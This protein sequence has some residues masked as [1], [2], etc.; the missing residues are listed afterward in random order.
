MRCLKCKKE[1]SDNLLRCNFCNTKVKTV[2]PICGTVNVITSEFCEGCGLQL[3]KYCPECKSVNLPNV[4]QCRK[5]GAK[6]EKDDAIVTISDLND[7]NKPE[8]AP[9]KENLPLSKP[10]NNVAQDDNEPLVLDKADEFDFA[11]EQENSPAETANTEQT[12]DTPEKIDEDELD[13]SEFADSEFENPSIEFEE[14]EN[15]EPSEQVIPEEKTDTPPKKAEEISQEIEQFREELEDDFSGVSNDQSNIKICDQMKCKKLI[16]NAIRNPDK[17]IIGMSAPEGSGKSTVLKYLFGDLMNENHAWLWGECSANSQISPFGIFQEMILTFFNMPNF[18]NMSQDFLKQAKTMLSQTLPNFSQTEIFNLF[19]FLYPTL[20]ANFEDILVN[21]DTTFELLE[22]LI[23]EISKKANLIIVIDDFDMIDGA[24]YEFLSYFVDKGYLGNS[25]KLLITYKD[26]RITQGYFY[27]ENI[28]QNQYEDI[29]LS[30][31]TK[32]DAFNFIKMFF[33][34]TNPLP[35]NIFGQIFEYSQGNSAYIEQILI[36]FNEYKILTTKDGVTKYRKTSIEQKLPSNIYEIL[37]LRLRYLQKKQPSAFKML[38]TAAIMGNKFNIRLLEIIMKMKPQEFQNVTQL[39]CSS[40]YIAQFN[41]NI[42]EFKNTILWKF[43]YE[44]AKQNKD[45]VVLNEKIFDIINSFTL[46]SNALKALIA[47]SLNQ[48]LLALNIWT[49]NVKLCSY[50]GDEH[51]WALSQ[52]QCLK[53]AQETEPEN[54]LVIINNIQERLGKLLYT[55]KP[56]EAIVY[57]SNAISNALKINNQPKIIELAGYLSKSCSLTGNYVGVIEA[58]DTILKIVEP[59]GNKLE[60]ALIKYKKLKAIFSIGNSEEIYNLASN[61]I[62]P[63]VEQALSGVIPN[64]D[65][66]MDVIYETWLECN[67]TVAMAL[68]SQ[69]NKKAFDVLSVI[70]EIVLKNNVENKN[71]L[72]RLKLAKALAFSIQGDIKK[73]DDLLVEF[74]QETSKEIV[75][76]DIISMWNF[77]N[78]LNKLFKHEWQNIK[79]D[80][81]SVVTFANNYNDVL[82]KN[83]LKVFLGKILQEEGNLSKALDI[84][85]EQVTIFAKEKIAIGAMLCWYYIAKITLVTEGTDKALDISQK[86]L[87]VAKNPKISNYYFMVLYKR[88]IAEIYLI[89]GDTD[90][91]KMY[92]E[93]ALMIAK[94]YDLKFLK[95]SLYQL[96]SK[97]LEEM[98]L[99]KPQ[100]KANYAQN[101]I[102]TYKKTITLVQSLSIKPIEEEVQKNYA[103]FKAFCQ[104]NN[105]QV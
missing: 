87:D 75:E 66:S 85:N 17:L 103:S 84:F 91:A 76:P 90:A 74:S 86:A 45:F 64:N 56:T 39:L 96:Y 29:R 53:I 88:L 77:I 11:E 47:Q 81:Y 99:K 18:S 23:L 14:N 25:I 38:C 62:I 101:A 24:S 55:T 20:T 105:I 98:V 69:G 71:Y 95:I 48:K 65:I 32:K 26:N 5:C 4:S 83:L 35:E 58:I 1:I 27:S 6:F 37:N 59:L 40:A 3:L 33:N 60:T 2:C 10:E 49:E 41:T 50:L 102:N 54:N 104:L 42:F 46:S 7:N 93:K 78:I 68:I 67:L 73:S 31:L 43:V 30:K 57:L 36:L 51:L 28:A 34:G 79:Q 80:L 63:I 22:K 72:Q 19:N 61:E 21:K 89:K 8:A 82:V 92:I 13:L 44:K 15:N 16:V 94:Q 9:E 100:N 70:D 12:Q 97:Y 52:K